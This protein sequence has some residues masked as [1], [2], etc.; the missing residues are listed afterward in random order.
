MTL[1]WLICHGTQLPLNRLGRYGFFGMGVHLRHYLQKC[2]L[3]FLSDYP[4]QCSSIPVGQHQILSTAVHRRRHLFKFCVGCHILFL[5]SGPWNTHKIGCSR[6]GRSSKVN[7]NNHV[8]L[9]IGQV[10]RSGTLLRTEFFHTTFTPIIA[11]LIPSLSPPLSG[12]LLNTWLY[13]TIEV[14]SQQRL[15]CIS[16]WLFLLSCHIPVYLLL[17]IYPEG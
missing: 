9:H 8:L 2:S 14:F 5:Y 17:Y 7:S 11:R 3:T 12:R 16:K 1:G 15:W 10:G 6:Y 4:L 13:W